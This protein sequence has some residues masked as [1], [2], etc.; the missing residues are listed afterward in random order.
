MY[1]YHLLHFRL[2]FLVFAICN[3]GSFPFASLQTLR[4]KGF[5]FLFQGRK[6]D[7][8]LSDTL[9]PE[10]QSIFTHVAARSYHPAWLWYSHRSDSNF[11]RGTKV[12]DY[13]LLFRNWQILA[14]CLVQLLF[15]AL[16]FLPVIVDLFC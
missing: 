4:E 1:V 12:T 8:L 3:F 16:L 6:S 13:E 7:L 2:L 9:V 15:S 10:L 11:I 5:E 14:R